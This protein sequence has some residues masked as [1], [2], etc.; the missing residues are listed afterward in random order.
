MILFFFLQLFRKSKC[1][2]IF[3]ATQKQCERAL[4]NCLSAVTIETFGSFLLSVQSALYC[5]LEQMMVLVAA[6]AQGRVLEH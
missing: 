6:V 5:V 3:S 2:K 1:L 4:V